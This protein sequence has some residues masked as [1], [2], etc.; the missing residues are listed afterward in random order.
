MPL[1]SK[2]CYL[3]YIGKVY[4]N[5]HTC[6]V[7][8]TNTYIGVL[9][10]ASAIGMSGLPQVFDVSL[11]KDNDFIKAMH[12]LLLDVHINKGYLICQESSRRF[13]IDNGIPNMKL[14]ES[15]V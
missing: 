15:E 2:I 14:P 4:S 10:A 1:L 12:N 5:L 6:P 11:L 13:P 3:H 7:F 9:E 8:N